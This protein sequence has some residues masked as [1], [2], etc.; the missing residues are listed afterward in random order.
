MI[1]RDYTSALAE[2]SASESVF[3]TA[4]AARFDIPRNV[5]AKACAA[6]KLERVAHGAYRSAFNPAQQTD[7]LAAIW[8]LT[9]PGKLSHERMQRGDWDGVAIGG[10]TAAA[11]L[12]IGDFYLSPYRIFAPKRFNTRNPD[13]HFGIRHINRDDI[14]FAHGIPVTKTERTLVDLVLD[15]EDPSLI[16]NAYSDALQSDLSEAKL[17]Q[18]VETECKGRHSKIARE[19]FGKGH[20]ALQ[21]GTSA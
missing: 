20:H 2:L 11:L 16:Q 3:T 21:I 4:Q 7:E 13:A 12:D 15:N 8:K 10:T 5:L 14:S 9:A 19:I 6:G 18:L 1:R 17:A